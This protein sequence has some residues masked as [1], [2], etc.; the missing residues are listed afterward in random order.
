VGDLVAAITELWEEVPKARRIVVKLD[1]GFSGEGNAVLDLE[2]LADHAPGRSSSSAR[3]RRIEK[4]LPSLRF[5]AADL[6]WEAYRDQFNA[7]GGICEQ[8]IDGDGKTSP[9]AQFRINPLFEVQAV[10]THDQVLGGPSGLVFQGATFPADPGYRMRI[11]EMGMRV[12]KELAS[13]GVMGRYGVDFLALPGAG[14]DDHELYAVEINLRQGG[15][16]HPLNTLKF[17]TDGEY[18]DATGVFRTA[19][20]QER[21]YF[22]TDTLSAQEY[23]GM[24]PSDLVDLLVVNGVHFRSDETGVLFHL[25]GCLSEYG[26]LGCTSVAKDVASALALYDQTIRLIDEATGRR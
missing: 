2:P 15:T 14:G 10:S 22:A 6:G 7:M 18:D 25:L 24:L 8:W 20:G 19:Q 3:R 5:E 11:Q 12:G 1:E 21:S 17:I 26:K 16:T 13:A 9:S 23:R 4:A